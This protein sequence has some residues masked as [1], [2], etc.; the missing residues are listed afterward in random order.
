MLIAPFN[1]SIDVFMK[2]IRFSAVA[3]CLSSSLNLPQASFPHQ[4]QTT[5][6]FLSADS[7]NQKPNPVNA[8]PFAGS[9]MS[10]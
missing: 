1:S 10:S 8:P 7:G 4:D 2:K 9:T 6:A 5:F 3:F